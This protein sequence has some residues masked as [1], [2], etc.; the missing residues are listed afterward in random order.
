MKIQ[1]YIPFFLFSILS[2]SQIIEGGEIEVVQ[3]VPDKE[4]KD[5]IRKVIDKQADNMPEKQSFYQY[6]SYIKFLI[7]TNRDS[8]LNDRL[9]IPKKSEKKKEKGIVLG[10]DEDITLLDLLKKGHI[11]IG[12]RAIQHYY[13]KQK[14]YKNI[15]KANR[16]AGLKSPLYEFAAMDVQSVNLKDPYFVFLGIKYINPIS[17]VGLSRYRYQVIDTLNLKGRPTIEMKFRP[18]GDSIKKHLRGTI[19]IDKETL[20]IAQF[21]VNEASSKKDNEIVSEYQLIKGSWFPVKQYFKFNTGRYDYVAETLEENKQGVIVLDTLSKSQPIMVYGTTYFNA[22]KINEPIDKKIFRGHESEIDSK[23]YNLTQEEWKSYRQ[24]IELDEIEKS[25]YLNIDSLG[26]KVKADRFL[27]YG[28]MALSGY[29]PIKK[30][31][32][33]L[34]SLLNYNE[35]EGLRLGAGFKTNY[36]FDGRWQFDGNIAYGLKDHYWKYSL[37]ASY[38]ISKPNYGIIGIHYLDDV[39][40]FGN[41][42]FAMKTPYRDFR[43]NLDRFHNQWFT[44]EKN[45]SLFYQQDFFNTATFKIKASRNQK[46]AAFDYNYQNETLFDFFDLE[47]GVKWSPKSKF[48]RTDYGK[49]TLE[50]NFPVF[51]LNATQGLANLGGDFEYTKLDFKGQHQIENPIGKLHFQIN[52]GIVFG[53]VPLMNLYAGNGNSNL[54]NNV[55]KNFNIAGTTSFETMGEREFFSDRFASIQIKQYFPTFELW[56]KPI[57]TNLVYRGMVGNLDDPEKH[58]LYFNT[59]ENYYQEAGVEV[60]NL[61]LIFGLGSYYRFGAYHLKDQGKNFS[62]KLTAKIELF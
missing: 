57:F 60:N 40:P 28:R 9:Y 32:L 39:S 14:G 8:I 1:F 24:G 19:W 15:V 44:K 6:N 12:E 4:S 7:T 26:E 52:S 36:T 3:I 25:T 54:R 49:I 42:Q 38:L 16:I 46:E 51:Q 29:Y 48:A 53:E 50:N 13:S 30:V 37:G 55:F 22:L 61:F 18:I 2:F 59:L 27:K 47:L 17:K 56:K 43:E 35:Y 10:K 33:D 21:N 11:F 34:T 58:S 23:A 5:F 41:Q 45:G 62:V 20:G 31:D